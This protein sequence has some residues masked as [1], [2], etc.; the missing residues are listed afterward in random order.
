MY[1]GGPRDST[2]LARMKKQFFDVFE[3]ITIE[4]SKF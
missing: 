4:N 2:S 3:E 1:M